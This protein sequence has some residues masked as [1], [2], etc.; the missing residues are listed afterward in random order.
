MMSCF[1]ALRMRMKLGF[2]PQFMRMR[3]PEFLGDC[4]M[5]KFSVYFAAVLAAVAMISLSVS[6]SAQTLSLND[7]SIL[8]SNTSRV[9]VNIGAIDY[10]DQGQILKNLIGSSD[11]GMEPLQDRQIWS[12]AAGGGPPSS[13]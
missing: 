3:L 2:N 8:Q 11:P 6:A 13:T 5:K 1:A 9:G 4:S 10:W 7:G 12:L